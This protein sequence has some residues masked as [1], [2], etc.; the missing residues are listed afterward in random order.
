MPE[1]LT[2]YEPQDELPPPEPGYIPSKPSFRTR[3]EHWI[4]GH[5]H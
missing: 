4:S 5:Q 2:W 1:N 3:F